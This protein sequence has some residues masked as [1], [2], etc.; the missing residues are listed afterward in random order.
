MAALRIAIRS[1]LRRKVRMLLIGSLVGLGTFLIVF[2]GT[3]ASSAKSGS[4]EAIISHFTGDLVLYSERSKEAPSPFSFQNPL[5]PVAEAGKV[6]AWLG[7]HPLVEAHAGIAQNYGLIQVDDGTKKLDIPF[8]FYATDPE[9][10]K[11]TFENLEIT[12]GS[13]Y[14]IAGPDPA[15]YDP[16][17]PGGV[18]ISE[19]QAETYKS[20]YGVVL[21]PGQK[22]T[23]LSLTSGGSVN[24]VGSTFLG[25]FKPKYYSNVFNYISFLDIPTYAKLYNFTGVSAGS[26][27][28]GLNQALT[29]VSD[30]DIFGLAETD[31]FDAIDVS[32]LVSEELTGY[33]QIA[34]RLK[35][36]ADPAAFLK[37]LEA[38]GFAVKTVPWD[39]ASSFFATIADILQGV[40]WGAT[41]LIFLIVVLILMNTLI[42]NILERSGEIGTYRAIGADKSFVSAI[43]LYESFFLNGSAALAGMLLSLVLILALGQSVQLPD[44]V[45]QYLVGGGPLTIRLEAGPFIQGFLLVVA[46]SV[47][48]TLYPTRVAVSVSPMKAL[49][50]K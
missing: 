32:T 36:G 31:A 1:L 14:G 33:T 3:F 50:G 21:K 9:T 25:T 5:P 16:S 38:Q 30:D 26:L 7:Q 13:W 4:R 48:A 10:Y 17:L 15:A 47:L 41:L 37:D 2:G 27:P 8:L 6:Q 24:A 40:I 39:Q 35:A 12:S 49:G 34:V 42:I 18:L 29:A 46:V 45:A 28:E 23:F 20:K 43:F 11:S 44:L 19:A 22:I